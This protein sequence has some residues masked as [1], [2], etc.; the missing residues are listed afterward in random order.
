[1]PVSRRYRMAGCRGHRAIGQPGKSVAETGP[2]VGRG[3]RDDFPSSDGQSSAIMG[4]GID[5]QRDSRKVSLQQPVVPAFD[6]CRERRHSC[7]GMRLQFLPPARRDEL[8]RSERIRDNSYSRRRAIAEI[9]LRTSNRGFS[10][11]S[12]VRCLHGRRSFRRRRKLVDRKSAANVA[13]RIIGAGELRARGYGRPRRA[14]KAPLDADV[15]SRF[16]LKV[17]FAL[18]ERLLIG[19][20]AH[21][22][23]EV[24]SAWWPGHR[25][26]SAPKNRK[27][28]IRRAGDRAQANAIA[29]R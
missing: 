23:R 24:A 1:M 9:P 3:A 13:Q 7:T 20:A 6:G 8:V 28:R 14:A 17:C 29:D 19:G 21:C 12:R 11:L 5:D 10:Y 16:C 18:R 27:T 26:G 22:S 2:F 4:A 25:V 15:D